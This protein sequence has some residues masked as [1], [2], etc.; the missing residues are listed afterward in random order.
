MIEFIKK[1]KSHI[2]LVIIILLIA[3]NVTQCNSIKLQ[4][5][6]AT[7]NITA[8]TD[9]IHVLVN[10]A[11]EL[12]YE[13]AIL[14]LDKSQLQQANAELYSALEKEKGKVHQL[15]QAAGNISNPVSDIANVIT[16]SDSTVKMSFQDSTEHSLI[17]GFTTFS[18]DTSK[19]TFTFNDVNT[20]ITD[21]MMRFKLTT[22]LVT[23][24]GITKI[25]ITPNSPRL[26][27][28]EITGAIISDEQIKSLVTPEKNKRFGIG[29]V[30]GI[31]LGT[32]L[33]F[34]PIVGIGLSYALIKF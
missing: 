33:Q 6:R 24:D 13:K 21:N 30:V 8:L 7:Q 5:D 19:S 29:P 25:F 2:V 12:T 34:V 9:S 15:I 28:D 3:I 14:I 23:K 10:N 32:N 20:T 26:I 4:K 1:Y 31:G 11:N 22:G 18:L 16:W 17:K 27:I